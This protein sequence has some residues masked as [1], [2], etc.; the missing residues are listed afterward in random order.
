MR[1]PGTI[2]LTRP[3]APCPKHSGYRSNHN[4]P[5]VLPPYDHLF[6]AGTDSTI[7]ITIPRTVRPPVT[8][9]RIL[10]SFSCSLPTTTSVFARPTPL[11][12][13]PEMCD[14]NTAFAPSAFSRRLEKRSL[15]EGDLE[16]R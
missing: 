10:I 4:P 7:S 13:A 9:L 1:D 12:K 5:H 14:D 16:N 2:P 15:Q 8:A 11:P 6:A 3:P